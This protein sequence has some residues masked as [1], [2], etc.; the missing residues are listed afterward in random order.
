MNRFLPSRVCAL[1]APA[2]PALVRRLERRRP[3]DDSQVTAAVF[4]TLA[5]IGP[6]NTVTIGELLE[7]L[8][9]SLVASTQWNGGARVSSSCFLP[10]SRLV[11]DWC[12]AV[13]K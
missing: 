6:G 9:E 10:L 2:T 12:P 3:E 13:A 7:L 8:A 11:P 5:A 1:A 4:D